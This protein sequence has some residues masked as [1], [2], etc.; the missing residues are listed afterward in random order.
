MFFIHEL[1]PIHNVQSDSILS[2]LLVFFLKLGFQFGFFVY[3]VVCLH[4]WFSLYFLRTSVETS[5]FSMKSLL[6]TINPFYPIPHPS[7]HL[8]HISIRQLVSLSLSIF[9]KNSFVF[10]YLFQQQSTLRSRIWWAVIRYSNTK[11]SYWYWFSF[12]WPTSYAMY[13]G[14]SSFS[15]PTSSELFPPTDLS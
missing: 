7:I 8:F 4:Y 12:L 11:S 5:S 13:L 2:F 15:Q 9:F 14:P 10:I 6:I 3:F 1:R